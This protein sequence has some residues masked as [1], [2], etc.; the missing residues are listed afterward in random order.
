MLFPAGFLLG[1]PIA[2]LLSDRVFRN[3]KAVLLL[4]MSF[5]AGFIFPLTGLIPVPSLIVMAGIFFCIE[6]FNSCGNVIYANIKELLPSTIS[7]TAMSAVNFFT[8][9]GDGFFQ[10]V[11]GIS[12]ERFSLQQG[13]LPAE[14][15]SFAFSLCFFQPLWVQ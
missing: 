4:A 1:G 9:A 12:I 10:H 15:F 8:M 7:G 3:R 2:G 5:Y 14:A 13:Q 11:M 6:F